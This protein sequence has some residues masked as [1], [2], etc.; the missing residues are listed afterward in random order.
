MQLFS[1]KIK[2]FISFQSN[3]SAFVIGFIEPQCEIFAAAPSDEDYDEHQR[4]VEE[5]REP[6]AAGVEQMPEQVHDKGADHHG[7]V[8]HRHDERQRQGRRAGRGDGRGLVIDNGLYHPVA[9]SREQGPDGEHR[10]VAENPDTQQSRADQP[11]RHEV[12]ILFQPADNLVDKEPREHDRQKEKRDQHPRKGAV[13]LVVVDEKRGVERHCQHGIG[14]EEIEQHQPRQLTAVDTFVTQLDALLG[15]GLRTPPFEEER[16][17]QRDARQRV[18]QKGEV[19]VD[20][21]QIARDH[22]G[23]NERQV[24]DRRA[25]T[26]LPDAVVAREIIDDEARGQGNDHA[27][28]DAEDTTDDDQPRH[29]AGEQ[30]RHAAQEEDREPDGQDRQFVAAFGELSRE[31]YEGD[32]QQ[33]RQR[34]EH[35]YLEVRDLGKHLVQIAQNGRDG[36]SGQRRDGRHGPDGQQDDER[37]GTFSGFDFHGHS[38]I[39]G[40]GTPA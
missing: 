13:D 38:D 25:V 39:V 22:G 26:Q 18:D 23:H 29:T 10:P 24:V 12:D 36:Q 3:P 8:V 28:P 35:L 17:R 40:S 4:G 1:T 31:Q 33:R 6:I 34:R 32:Y 14:G 37:D 9:E 15:F 11:Q 5:E 19:P 7:E 21:G 16:E 27:G 2:L 20:I 30:A